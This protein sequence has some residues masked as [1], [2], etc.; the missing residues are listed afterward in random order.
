MG[1]ASLSGSLVELE[2]VWSGVWLL[3]PPR[4]Q[5]QQGTVSILRLLVFRV[6][7]VFP[8]VLRAQGW[9]W[10]H[11]LGSTSVG[12]TSFVFYQPPRGCPKAGSELM[13]KSPLSFAYT[14]IIPHRGL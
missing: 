12:R 4:P 14:L 6:Q 7:A 13:G 11:C 10:G 9:H 5:L 2:T 1:G 3:L 8:S